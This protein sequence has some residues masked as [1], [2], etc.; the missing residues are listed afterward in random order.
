[1]VGE[2]SLSLS[3]SHMVG[4]SG[5]LFFTFSDKI[6]K[7]ITKKVFFSIHLTQNH[8]WMIC[9]F[10]C[11]NLGRAYHLGREAAHLYIHQLCQHY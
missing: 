11:R 4:Q 3:S 2:T 7:F 6:K 8:R 10:T 1:M 9:S 5:F